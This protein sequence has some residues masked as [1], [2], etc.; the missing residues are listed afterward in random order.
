[1]N[2]HRIH[3]SVLVQSAICGLLLIFLCPAR[4]LQS[5][6]EAPLP[7]QLSTDPDLCAYVPCRDVLPGAD[8]FSVRKGRPSYVEGYRSTH[9]GSDHQE[10]NGDHED[11]SGH[12]TE[13]AEIRETHGEL[14]GY[15]FLSTDIVDIP[16]YSGKPVVT[17]IGMDTRGIITGIKI[18]KHSE[19]ILLV[20]IPETELTKFINQYVGKFVGSKI[21]IGRTEEGYIGVDA[22]SGATVTVISENQVIMHSAYKIATQVGILKAK[23]RTQAE[24]TD[25]PPVKDWQT[26]IREGS[27]QRLTVEPSEMGI[28]DTGQ[29]YIDMYF[30]YL[31]EPALGRSILGDYG[32]RRLMTDL[33]PGEH[34]IF[35]IANG[36]GSFKGSGFVRGGMFDRFQVAQDMDTFT[37]RDSD[38]QNLYGIHTPGAPEYRESG[39][40]ILR[41]PAFSVAYPWNLVFL[42]NKYDKKTA[43]KSF[44]TFSQE[45]WLPAHYMVGGHPRYV[46]PD[47]AWL[48]TWKN[49]AW[50]LGGFSLILLLTVLIFANRDKLVRASSRR[51]KTPL[52][53][54]LDHQYRG[55][56]KLRAG[57]TL[58]H[59]GADLVSLHYL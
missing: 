10:H 38:Y 59:P 57:A 7:A 44:A 35:I 37:F 4:A 1:M 5:T 26:M 58:H 42:A 11:R 25:A 21:E 24:L 29:P 48:R 52:E 6:Y 33:K 23:P 8:S 15:V 20:G 32:Y 46:R 51:D 36:T 34:A 40:F 12:E 31:N 13:D 30:G 45:Y 28:E 16:G 49:K 43:T 22:I 54:D 17:L 3:R 39:I 19:P 9:E 47:P 27:V 2:T 41:N 14:V 50:E 53:P 55:S 56:R 18:L